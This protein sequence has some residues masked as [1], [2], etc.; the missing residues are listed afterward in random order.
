[1][2][3]IRTTAIRATVILLAAVFTTAVAQTPNFEVASVKPAKPDAQPYS[4]FPLGP[5]DVYVPNG[6]LFSAA[7]YP[8]VTFILFAYKFIGN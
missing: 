8:L 3:M 6:G 1:M 5:G 7:G 2:S 4:N